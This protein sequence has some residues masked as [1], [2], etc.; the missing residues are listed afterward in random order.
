[1]TTRQYVY[2]EPQCEVIEMPC[3]PDSGI[4]FYITPG[5]NISILTRLA[6]KLGCAGDNKL[7]YGFT[8]VTGGKLRANEGTF[9]ANNA[10]QCIDKAIKAKKDVFQ[11]ESWTELCEWYLRHVRGTDELPYNCTVSAREEGY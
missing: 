1:M 4:T 3:D 9:I 11:V 8:Y 5:N 10:S 2:P 6:D 7:V